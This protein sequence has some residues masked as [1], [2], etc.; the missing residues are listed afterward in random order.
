MH[1]QVVDPRDDAAFGEWYAV[2]DASAQAARPGE[3]DWL[4]GELRQQ[5]LE[6][7]DRG[8]PRDTATTALLLRDDGGDGDDDRAGDRV[9][10]AVA[11]ARLDLPLRDNLSL[12]ELEL[13][14][15][16]AARRRGHGTTLLADVRERAAAAGRIT[17][18]AYVDEPPGAEAPG[19][20]APGRPFAE[21]AGF[22]CGQTEVRRDLDLP[23]DAARLTAAERACA[24][25]AEGYEITTW[26]VGCPNALVEDRALLSRRMSTDIPL[27]ELPLE[28]EEWDAARVRR[29]E[30][31]SAAQDRLL[32]AAGALDEAGRLVAVTELAVPRPEPA[33]AYQWDTIVLQ[34]HR[35]HR[36]GMLVKAAALR[37]LAVE[38]PRTR[39][40]STWNAEENTHMIAVNEALG[41]RT[42]GTQSAWTGPAAG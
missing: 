29:E 21:H 22:R 35:G 3:P 25:Y 20:E 30:A 41:F 38:S 7:L 1:I 27:G 5:L 4:P 16:P 17:L 24:P 11:A 23:A 31:H 8:G 6:G 34:E 18:L 15:A 14:V 13:Y 9:G 39:L 2:V 42:A 40:L 37:R 32:V 26:T 36:L 33:R 28:E 12:A 19:A 10:V